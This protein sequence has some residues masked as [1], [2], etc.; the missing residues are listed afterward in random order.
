MGIVRAQRELARW[1]Q[2]TGRT[3]SSRSSTRR[4][5]DYRAVSPRLVDAFIAGEASLNAWNMP[6]ATGRRRS[7][8]APG[9]R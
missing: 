9:C 7:G 8:A 6:D 2:A 4:G 3:S 1:A 5:M